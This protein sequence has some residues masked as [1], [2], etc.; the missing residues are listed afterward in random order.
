MS[1]E[2]GLHPWMENSFGD[3]AEEYRREH[4]ADALSKIPYM[5][6]VD[7]YQHKVFENPK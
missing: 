2:P 7:E 1:M 6:C 4:L 3:K 5:L